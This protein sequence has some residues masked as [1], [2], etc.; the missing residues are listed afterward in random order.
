LKLEIP[1][2]IPKIVWCDKCNGTGYIGRIVL[3]EVFEVNEDVK[4]MIVEWRSSLDIYGRA[5][6][7][8]YFTMKEDGI[9]KMIEGLTTLD[10]IRRVL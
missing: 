6:E 2:K 1:K 10:E 5:R 3:V 8:G 4:K 9:M 7:N